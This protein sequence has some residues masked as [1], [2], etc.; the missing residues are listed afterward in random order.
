MQRTSDWVV[1][2]N[3]PQSSQATQFGP[4]MAWARDIATGEPVYVLELDKTRTGAKC[5]C[6]CPSCELPLTAVNAAK[7]EYIKRP[8]FRHP[9]GAEKSDCMYLSAR[10]AAM[11]LLRDQGV[12]LLPRRQMSG[13]VVGLSGFQHE[14]WVE[15]PPERVRIRDFN[16]RDRTA[17]ILTLEDGRQLRIQLIGTGSSPTSIDS[18]GHPIP[19]ILLD[20]NEPAVASM[21]PKELRSR[22]TLVADSLCWLS[23]WNDQV[24]KDQADEEA[25]R[26]ADEFMD[27]VPPNASFWEGIDPK[28]RR[29]TLLHF[30]VKRILSESKEIRVPMLQARAYEI[31][32]NGEEVE[33][34]WDRPSELIPL[35]DVQLE[36]RF[37]RVIPDVI[38]RVPAEHG[39]IMMIEVTI[40]N[41]IDDE[42][43]ARI[44]QKNVPTLEINLSLS[45]GLISRADLEKWVVH[46]LET[47]RWLHHPEIHLQTHSLEIE[48][49]ARVSAIDE[50]EHE[51]QE[52]RKCV[53]ATPLK[54]IAQDFLKAVFSY[55]EYDREGVVDEPMREAIEQAKR[56]VKGDA[57]KLAIHG[58]PEAT[59]EKLTGGRQAIIP[60]ILSIQL[61]RG[62]GYR[63]ESAMEVMN[64]IRQSADQNSSNHTIYLIAEK[65]Y[66]A[67]D[68]PA[69]PSWY[70]YWVDGI[71]E[72]INRYEA[73]YIRDGKFDR[74][75]SLLFPEIAASLA[76]GYGTVLCRRKKPKGDEPNANSALKAVR[77]FYNDGAFRHNAP[78]IIFDD[79]LR[80]AQAIKRGE[81]FAKWFEIWS[82]RYN[83]QYD[84][85]P[86]VRF[87]NAA[88]FVGAIDHWHS[89]NS[90]VQKIKSSER[91]SMQLME[92]ENAWLGETATQLKRIEAE[93]PVVNLYALEKGRD[94]PRG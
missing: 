32:N 76:N 65:V 23:H 84:L 30:E 80:E 63:L 17:A 3:N 61:G 90:Y 72:S 79:V 1:N 18:D 36:K 71:K 74:L 38:A 48:V 57:D 40:T 81:P 27:L 9:D 35:L 45:G 68:S 55:A 46:G 28:F 29:E 73:T 86:I 19:T 58:Y 4:V 24:L 21:S 47:K 93:K 34:Q 50:A 69:N 37:G 70:T 51:A 49:Q 41:H 78:R 64:A 59:D 10:L 20:V 26:L 94:T 8:H 66:R 44:R 39:E 75:L 6:E 43:L 33:R 22:I 13:Q 62:V 56:Y 52:Y 60:R 15:Q 77:D 91:S 12:L 25:R 54:E 31:A 67:P 82:D 7:T 89:W 14:A 85:H 88:G 92:K 5:G 53:L 16:F 87:L 11:Q 2:T 83:L 42:R